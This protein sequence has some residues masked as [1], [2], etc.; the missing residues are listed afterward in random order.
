MHFEHKLR[1]CAAARSLAHRIATAGHAHC[2][3]WEW[4]PPAREGQRRGRSAADDGH[5]PWC[6][7]LLMLTCTLL[8]HFASLFVVMSLPKEEL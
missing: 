7:V 1:I 3:T 2:L 8:L 4:K 6:G 5:A